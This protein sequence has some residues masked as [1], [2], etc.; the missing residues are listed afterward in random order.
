MLLGLPKFD[1]DPGAATDPYAWWSASNDALFV[2]NEAFDA[3]NEACE[4]Y[5]NGF[6]LKLVYESNEDPQTKKKN[7]KIN[8]KKEQF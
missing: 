4:L 5:V 8:K 1:D 3:L 2:L 6:K 7:E